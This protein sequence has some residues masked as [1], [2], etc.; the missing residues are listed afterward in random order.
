MFSVILTKL[1]KNNFRVPVFRDF[2]YL[3]KK[4]ALKA[5]FLFL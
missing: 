2:L 1:Q 4:A 5:A 3:A